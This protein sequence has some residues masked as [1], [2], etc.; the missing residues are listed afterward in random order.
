MPTD[1]VSSM[2]ARAGPVFRRYQH[3]IA[4]VGRGTGVAHQFP[5]RT[6]VDPTIFK[7]DL[8]KHQIGSVG[9]LERKPIPTSLVRSKLVGRPFTIKPR[10]TGYLI[11]GSTHLKH[12]LGS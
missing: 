4:Y 2:I 10:Q 6:G 5:G 12:T 9:K 3:E 11:V 1:W 7:P 8:I